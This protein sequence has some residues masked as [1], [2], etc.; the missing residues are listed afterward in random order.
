MDSGSSW[1]KVGGK[2]WYWRSLI[3]YAHVCRTTDEINGHFMIFSSS[4]SF[5]NFT[6]LELRIKLNRRWAYIWII[7]NFKKFLGKDFTQF[8]IHI[9]SK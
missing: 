6:C 1:C 2:N 5:F 9:Y 7:L 3:C 4:S 8:S